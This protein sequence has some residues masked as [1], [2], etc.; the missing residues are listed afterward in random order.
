MRKPSKVAVMA[1]I[2]GIVLF[3]AALPFGKNGWEKTAGG[4]LFVLAVAAL[5][6]FVI[7]GISSLATRTRDRAELP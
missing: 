2:A 4:T 6:T 5:A 1:L 3:V 7:A